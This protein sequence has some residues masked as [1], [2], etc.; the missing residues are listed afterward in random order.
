MSKV[1]SF[2]LS[3]ENPREAQ[4]SEIIDALVGEGYSLRYVVVDALLSYRKADLRQSELNYIM[5]KLQNF[6]S[7]LDKEPTTKSSKTTLSN[8]F[9][10]SVKQSIRSGVSVE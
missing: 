1:Y 4:A 2:R 7:A 5:E 3:Q 6:F 8:S 9:L 10:D